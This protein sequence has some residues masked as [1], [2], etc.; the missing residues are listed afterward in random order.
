MNIYIPESCCD[1]EFWVSNVNCYDNGLY[2]IDFGVNNFTPGCSNPVFNL[3]II[4][5]LSG[6][7]IGYFSN[8]SLQN[9]SYGL[10]NFTANLQLTQNILYVKFKIEV[11][12]NSYESCIGWFE[13]DLPPCGDFA[14]NQNKDKTENTVTNSDIS[15][16]MQIMPNPANSNLSIRYLFGNSDAAENNIIRI[17]DA[18]AR[19]V[20]E[21]KP[22]N[23][24][25][26][27]NLDVSRF[28]QGIYFVQLISN[29]RHILSK[30][31]IINH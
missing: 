1:L 21:F 2:N 20:M 19:P 18:T 15:S 23:I 8:I 12:C 25:G 22:E 7:A 4:D 16:D 24:Q 26:E 27:I 31:L 10:N 17:F 5:P 13:M 9:L 28:A 30:R 14:I 3:S 29:N 6:Q 11:F